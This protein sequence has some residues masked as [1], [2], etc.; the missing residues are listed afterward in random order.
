MINATIFSEFSLTGL[1][2]TTTKQRV[3]LFSFTL[4]C[5]SVILLVNGALIVTII[6]EEKLHEPMYIFLCNLCINSI[7]G[8]TGF[9]PK[10]LFDLLS[11][12]HVISYTGC[13]FQ[14]FVIYLY[15]ATDFS[16]LTLMAY[17]RYV[18]ICRPLEYHSVMTK[19]R[20]VL[21]VCFSRFVPFLCHGI[22]VIMTSK[23]ELC[24]SHIGKLY[25]D[26]WSILKLSC[27]SI[28][29]NNI[30]GFMVIVFYCGHDLFI[31]CSYVLLVKSA[32]KSREGRGKFMQT[33]VPH[34]L[35]LLNVT[36]ALLFDLMYAR[37][38]SS[39]ISQSVKNFMAVQFLMIP[40]I[41]NPIIYGLKLTQ[42]RNSFLSLCTDNK[43]WL[44][45]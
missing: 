18:A 23:L 14:V 29:T 33:C 7:F 31:M 16:I 32:L 34:F 27:S 38:G 43:R 22:V 21:L 17:D 2:G 1:N 5:Y 8:T 44:K 35:C 37:Y 20:V 6:L 11:N 25:C 10:F 41:L 12:T 39:S 40:P 36:V 28:T 30:V 13:L 9:Y 4:L 42:V 45:D 3:T 15:V 24:G 19:H 26:N